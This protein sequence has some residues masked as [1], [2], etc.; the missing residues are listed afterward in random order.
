MIVVVSVFSEFRVKCFLVSKPC[1]WK[2]AWGWGD[3]PDREG[4][5][6]HFIMSSTATVNGTFQILMNSLLQEFSAP[7]PKLPGPSMP[8]LWVICFL[9]WAPARQRKCCLGS[10]KPIWKGRNLESPSKVFSWIPVQAPRTLAGTGGHVTAGCVFDWLLDGS[11][12]CCFLLGFW[13]FEW[14]PREMGVA[15]KPPGRHCDEFHRD[16]CFLNSFLV[17]KRGSWHCSQMD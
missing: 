2:N 9:I 5:A 17:I 14:D 6:F 4:E 8:P 15:T 16:F 3:N 12:V 13:L 7:V 11:Q 1:G 10:M